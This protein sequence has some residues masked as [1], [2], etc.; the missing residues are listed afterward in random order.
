[1]SGDCS[2]DGSK[3]ALYSPE[4]RGVPHRGAERRGTEHG[5]RRN[6]AGLRPQLRAGGGS[7]PPEMAGLEA[8]AEEVQWDC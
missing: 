2:D 5:E 1:M 8:Q 6:I 4:R 7:S 3:G